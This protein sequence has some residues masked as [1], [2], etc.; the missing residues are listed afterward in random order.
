MSSEKLKVKINGKIKFRG[1][2]IND[3]VQGFG[4]DKEKKIRF[5]IYDF[6][7]S[8]D[9]R[10]KI[11]EYFD[12]NSTFCPKWLKDKDVEFINLKSNYNIDIYDKNNER[13]NEEQIEQI[14]SDFEGSVLIVVKEGAI[15]PVAIKV[16]K[17][18]KPYNPFENM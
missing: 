15:Y 13:M 3:L 17:N 7:I 12:I 6:E 16:E 18:G 5:S 1:M 11:L 9:L 10:S 4:K 2:T 8:D 14:Y